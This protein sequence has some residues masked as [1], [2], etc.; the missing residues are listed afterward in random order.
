MTDTRSKTQVTVTNVG[1]ALID[2][3][4]TAPRG[5]ILREHIVLFTEEGE[6]YLKR[7]D[8]AGVFPTSLI[9]IGAG[10]YQREGA[11]L[12]KANFT[13][14]RGHLNHVGTLAFQ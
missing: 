10:T 13:A 9:V 11:I 2:K 7:I 8:D 3:I 4:K 12:E 6:W 14:D 1:P 5:V